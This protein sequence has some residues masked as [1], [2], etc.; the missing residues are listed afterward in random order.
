MIVRHDHGKNGPSLPPEASII[1]LGQRMAATFTSMRSWR[2][3]RLFN[4]VS[5]AGGQVEL[6]TDFKGSEPG[7]VASFWGLTPAND[8]ILANS[9]FEREYLRRR[10]A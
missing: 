2:T 10:L 4:R 6:V 8:P 5:P 1:P 3:R 9:L 7:D